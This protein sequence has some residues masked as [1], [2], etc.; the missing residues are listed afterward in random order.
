MNWTLVSS[1]DVVEGVDLLNS[2]EHNC[3]QKVKSFGLSQSK[4]YLTLS[5]ERLI[6]SKMVMT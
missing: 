1:N 4:I 2:D 6:I 3:S 5:R